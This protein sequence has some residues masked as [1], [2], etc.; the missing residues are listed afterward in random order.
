MTNKDFHGD[1]FY[2]WLVRIQFPELKH[3]IVFPLYMLE[4]L[5]LQEGSKWKHC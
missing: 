4:V 1:T 2:K 5:S 3:F